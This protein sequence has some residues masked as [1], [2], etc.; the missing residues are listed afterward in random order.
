MYAFVKKKRDVGADIA[1]VD[2]PE[3]EKE[4]VLVKVKAASICGTDVEV[5]NW[6][7]WAQSRVKNLPLILGH[8]L[9]GEIVEVGAEVTTLQEGDMVSA[10][11]HIVDGTCYQ[12]RTDRMHI[13]QNM[14]IL[15]V[16]RDGVF[17]EYVKLP[18]RNAWKNH[19]DL[20][21]AIASLQEP[22][23]NAVQSVLPKDH[24]EDVA[25]KN[26]AV[27]G[28]GPIGL[29]TI[30]VL[31]TIGAAKIFATAGGRNKVRMELAKKVGADMVLNAREEGQNLVKIV[32]QATDG[33]GVDVALEMSGAASAVRQ[34]F[35][36]LT[37]GG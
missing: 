26:I 31:K 23:G 37:P 8:E 32:R 20:D 19:P 9:A 34:A 33:K 15:G 21:P 30:A 17:A 24:I 2:T 29:M 25:G 12:C 16:D 14:E 13:C 28:C 3:I 18:E 10:E 6:N 7:Q 22:L 27:L 5:W 35:N 1:M 36:M 4:E 11:T